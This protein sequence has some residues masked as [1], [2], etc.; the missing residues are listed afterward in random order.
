[1]IG[2]RAFRLSEDGDL[3]SLFYGNCWSP[4]MNTATCQR[5]NLLPTI[6][7]CQGAPDPDCSCGHWC[8]PSRVA[9][10]AYLQQIAV[11][12]EVAPRIT[13]HARIETY[14]RHV[15]HKVGIRCEKAQVTELYADSCLQWGA[16][17]ATYLDIGSWITIEA[18]RVISTAPS[19]L[20][21]IP[22]RL[23]RASLRYDVPLS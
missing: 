2:Y 16:F 15:E 10:T 22:L 6:R 23:R 9:V 18:Q 12:A 13:V 17:G 7:T 19:D 1:M 11:Y 14:G 4:G 20:C 3:D 21:A 8:L 5:M